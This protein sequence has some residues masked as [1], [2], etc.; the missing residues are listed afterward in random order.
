M[1]EVHEP[2]WSGMPII[3]GDYTHVLPINED[4][5]LHETMSGEDCPCKPDKTGQ[6]QNPLKQF[7]PPRTVLHHKPMLTDTGRLRPEF[8]P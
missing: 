3:V 8:A 1:D 2:Q 5:R 7:E 4:D 6:T